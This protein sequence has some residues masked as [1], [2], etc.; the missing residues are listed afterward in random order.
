MFSQGE[1]ISYGCNGVCKVEGITLKNVPGSREMREYY[2]LKPVYQERGTIFCPVDTQKGALRRK[3]L[4][5]EES[6]QLLSHVSDVDCLEYANRKEFEEKCKTAVLSGECSEWAKVVK[7]LW[8]EQRY[9]RRAG[10]KMT[11]TQERFLKTAKDNLCGELAVSLHK[12]LFQI[13]S[14]LKE[15]LEKSAS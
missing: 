15:N 14:M 5:E 4:T 1:Y 12:E 8:N 6:Y 11:A 13:E 2:V 10:K 3:I 7:T 9:R